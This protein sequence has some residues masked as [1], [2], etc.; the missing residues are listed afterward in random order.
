MSF[1]LPVVCTKALPK[2]SFSKEARTF[3]KS[4]GCENE[5]SITVPPVKSNP[6]LNPLVTIEKIQSA[7]T[8]S[9]KPKPIKR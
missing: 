2:P 5:V 7:V 9:E 4:A 1:W 3:S 8:M 6:Q